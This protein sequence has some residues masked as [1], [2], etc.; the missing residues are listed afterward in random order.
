[1][2]LV[3]SDRPSLLMLYIVK[4]TIYCFCSIQQLGTSQG[5][6]LLFLQSGDLAEEVLTIID[7]HYA[8][9]VDM[10]KVQVLLT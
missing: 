3:N 8:D 4:D 6:L 9:S 7:P 2:I 1:M 10:S 5:F